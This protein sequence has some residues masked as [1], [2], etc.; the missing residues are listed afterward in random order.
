MSTL[1][2]S[3]PA[4]L[5]LLSAAPPA[6]DF[7][8]FCR[9]MNPKEFE[10]I[11]KLG[12][13]VSGE[14]DSL[15]YLQGQESDAFFVVNDGAVEIVVA[16]SEGENPTPV[17]YLSKGD[18]FG[19]IGLLLG[20]PRTAS[21]RVPETAT[22]LR[23]ERD[24]FEKLLATVPAFG[25]YLAIVLSC[26]LHKT[27]AQLHFYSHA[28]ELAGNLD[29]FDLPTVFQTIGFSRQ[30]G[31]MQIHGLASEMIGEFAFANGRP[32]SARYQ[33]LYGREALLQLFQLPPKG[34]FGFSR[35][36]EPPVVESPLDLPDINE[37]VLHAVHLRDELHALEPDLGLGAATRF[38]R[39]HS[40]MDWPHKDLEDCAKALWKRISA[41]PRSLPQLAA[42]LPFCRYG[43]VTVVTRLL[44]SKQIAPAELTP[45]GYR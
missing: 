12:R 28:T 1:S 6:D 3:E 9:K 17:A 21:V 5:A 10:Q 7:F 33:H 36:D 38:K 25:H 26:R 24:A 29:F 18:I 11:V 35:L 23:F 40:H 43:V 20:M 13:L 4:G 44:G 8:T 42:E 41:E 31:V 45:F 16:S 39:V 34:H 32:I 14:R 22:L 19:E 37:F 2:S 15:V 27:T 30:H